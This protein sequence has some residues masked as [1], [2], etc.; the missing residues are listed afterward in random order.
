[1]NRLASAVLVA[2]ALTAVAAPAIAQVAGHTGAGNPVNARST[3]RTDVGLR[4]Q[5]EGWIDGSTGNNLAAQPLARVD[6]ANRVSTLV[7]LGRC[8][9]ARA[10]ANE[11]GDRQMALRTRQ[12][13]RAD[14]TG[15]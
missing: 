10:L 15:A 14:R 6:L 13:C 4:G 2:A 3:M 7:E 11:A 5:Y 8:D 9:E 1:M 12:L